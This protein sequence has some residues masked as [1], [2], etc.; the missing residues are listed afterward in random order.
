MLKGI[1]QGQLVPPGPQAANHSDREVGEKRVMA[2]RL[3]RKYVRQMDFDKRNLYPSKRIT[4]RHAG[5]REPGRI[6]ENE[7]S[8]IG[9]CLMNAT[10][11]LALEVALKSCEVCAGNARRLGKSGID[12]LEGVRPVDGGLA[13]PEEIKVWTVQHQNTSEAISGLLSRASHDVEFAAA[14]SKMSRFLAKFD[15]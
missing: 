3:A 6:D 9:V 13:G 12:R 11:Q 2:E 1:L 15:Q 5:V 10:N 14:F 4:Q 7:C 8:S